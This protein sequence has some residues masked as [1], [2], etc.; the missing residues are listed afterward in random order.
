M[1]DGWS[2]D[3]KISVGDILAIVV[4][5]SAVFVAWFTLDKRVTIV[6]QQLSQKDIRDRWQDEARQQ[7]RADVLNQLNRIDDKLDRLIEGKK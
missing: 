2:L 7:L 3:R 4:A 5:I 6:E 1:M